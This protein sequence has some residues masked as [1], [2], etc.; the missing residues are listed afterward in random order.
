MVVMN[1]TC[2]V[3]ALLAIMWIDN[4]SKSSLG[5]AWLDFNFDEFRRASRT[6][7]PPA[8]ANH[9]SLYY[10]IFIRVV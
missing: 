4:A 10:A 1:T 9:A 7:L 3:Q 5:V 8:K 2:K 6:T